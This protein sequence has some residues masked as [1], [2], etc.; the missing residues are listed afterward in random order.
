MLDRDVCERPL[1]GADRTLAKILEASAASQIV[2]LP[3]APSF[4]GDL[5]RAVADDISGGPPGIDVVAR[6]LGMSDRTLQRRL[7]DLGASYREVLDEVRRDLALELM[8]DGELSISEVAA[9][10]GYS[11][12][13]A[14]RRSFRRWT[15]S[16]PRRF[17]AG[18]ER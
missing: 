18:H 15:E 8:R 17:R 2:A 3:A 12:A 5:R 14:F 16:S 1:A 13:S 7:Q 9:R 6:R 10:L 4:L 11:E